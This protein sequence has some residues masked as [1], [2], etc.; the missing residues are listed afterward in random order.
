MVGLSPILY[1]P[2]TNYLFKTIGLSQTFLYIGI[3]IIVINTV[4]AQFI[5]NPP[6]DWKPIRIKNKDSVVNSAVHV[7]NN[8]C[9]RELIKTL[10]R[11]K[12]GLCLHLHFQQD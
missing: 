9:W 10:S 5:K 7:D 6:A 3:G 11:I 12:Y 4:F 8:L 2:L 1:A